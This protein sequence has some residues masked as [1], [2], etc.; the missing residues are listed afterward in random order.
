M[1]IVTLVENHTD[2]D[3]QCEHGLA[4]YIEWGG[5]K[6]LLDAGQSGIFAENAKCLGVDIECV[7]YAILSHGH[8]D[9]ACGFEVFAQKNPSALV[10]MQ[11]SAVQHYFSKK[12]D[13]WKDIGIPT[14]VLDSLRGRICYVDGKQQIAE[15]VFLMSRCKGDLQAQGKQMQMYRKQDGV[16]VFDDFSHEQSLVFEGKNG[17]VIFNSCCH[18]GVDAILEEVLSAFPGK[19]VLAVLG[20]FHLMGAEGPDSMRD[21]EAEVRLLGEKLCRL[22]VDKFYTGHCTGGK[23]YSVLKEV[24]GDRLDCLVTGRV[25]EICE[26]S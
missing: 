19:K 5:N 26:N 25:I 2:N 16:F 17:L 6:F 23:A 13:G 14:R 9:H 1:K 24:L 4:F 3:L 10:Y 11:K 22:P 8:Y 18:G 15:G 12:C 7:D 20:G 21:S